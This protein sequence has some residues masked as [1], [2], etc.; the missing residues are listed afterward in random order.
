MLH[1]HHHA[2]P[3]FVRAL[4]AERA[5]TLPRRHRRADPPSLEALVAAA[6]G[7][8][9]AAWNDIVAR[10]GPKLLRIARA[11][12]LS[13]YEAQDAVQETWVRLLRNVKALRDPEAV[14][15]WLATTARN[16]SFRQHRQTVRETP[17][18]ACE[19][20]CVSYDDLAEIIAAECRAEL[21]RALVWL[22]PRQR[23]MIA[24]LL[25]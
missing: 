23:S 2:T 22:S 20:T 5:D 4:D 19:E 17:T 13:H 16:E 15:G 25:A 21:E 24:E 3:V 14:G 1:H 10:F 7:G 18:E 12:G 8:D 9:E 11:T 6:A